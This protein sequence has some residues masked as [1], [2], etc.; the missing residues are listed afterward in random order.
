MRLLIVDKQNRKLVFDS[1]V[2][3]LTWAENVETEKLVAFRE[4][5]VTQLLKDLE[6]L[7][8]SK[9]EEK[10]AKLALRLHFN[11]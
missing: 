3:D 9:P 7:R 1:E 6:Y 8:L 5:V 11:V 2:L 10:L 4:Y